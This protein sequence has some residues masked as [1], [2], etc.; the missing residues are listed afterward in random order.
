M[1]RID[2]DRSQQR[3]EF[4]L[5]VSL[6]KTQRLGIEFVQAQ[7]SD[8]VRTECGTQ[9][10]IPAVVLVVDEL[11]SQLVERVAL[12]GQSQAVGTSFVVAVF[13]LL[14]HGGHAHFE[15]FVEIARRDGEEFQA[16]EQRIS[17]VLGL[18]ED[19]AIEREPGSV[20]VEKVLRVIQ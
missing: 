4:F 1:R 5:A 16:L 14:H 2:R 8:S 17:L 6:N 10:G 15:E 20:A 19:T 11:V 3:V 13:D 7:H 18:F 9:A 12:G